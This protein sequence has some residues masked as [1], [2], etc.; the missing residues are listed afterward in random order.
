MSEGGYKIRD[1]EGVYYLTFTVV[2]WIDVFTRKRYK[3][4]LVDSL[5]FCQQE[6]GLKLYS[7]VMM[8]NHMHCVLSCKDNKLSDVIRDF[9]THTSKTI[10]KSIETEEGESRKDWMLE[11]FKN[12][13]LSNKRNKKYQFWK[14]DNHPVELYSNYFIDQKIAYIHENPVVAGLVYKPEEYIYSSA[15]N[16]CGEQGLLKIAFL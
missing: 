15:K 16:Y 4:I 11:Q 8:S 5:I 12:K 2:N 3:D 7:F 9:K 6:K 14:Q 13:G 1:Q 10:I